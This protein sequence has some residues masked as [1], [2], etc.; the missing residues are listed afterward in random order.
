MPSI[1]K[2]GK[3]VTT[4]HWNDLYIKLGLIIHKQMYFKLKFGEHNVLTTKLEI[5]IEKN[6]DVFII[7]RVCAVYFLSN[8]EKKND[9]IIGG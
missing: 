6:I 5:E 2:S 8:R 7:K 9:W 3:I 4:D 1:S